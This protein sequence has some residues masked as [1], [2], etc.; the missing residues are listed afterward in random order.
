MVSTPAPVLDPLLVIDVEETEDQINNN[1]GKKEKRK[2]GPTYQEHE[3]S[4]L[5]CSW[6]EVSED[7]S[8]GTDQAGTRFWDHISKCYHDAIP[9]PLRPIGSIKGCWQLI[10]HA[11]SKFSGC[12][13]HIDQLNP[14]GASSEDRLT[15]SLSLFAEL[16]GKTF[17]YLHCYNILTSSPKWN[18]YFHDQENKNIEGPKKKNSKRARS[19]PIELRR[20]LRY[21]DSLCCS[22]VNRSIGAGLT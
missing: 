15:R 5:C 2:K 18:E 3:D 20:N 17:T 10:S 14:S 7:P 9:L 13:K 21:Q 4:Q 22:N 12:I 19:T 8:V 6:I 11:V 1:A 16:Q